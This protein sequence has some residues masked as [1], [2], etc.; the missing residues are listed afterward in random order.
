MTDYELCV[1]R[2]IP[3]PVHLEIDIAFGALLA[4]SPWLFGFSG[5]ND[6]TP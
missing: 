6:L 4:A 5:R 2:V 3:L 1:M